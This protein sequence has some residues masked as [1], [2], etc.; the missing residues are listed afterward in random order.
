MRTAGKPP[1]YIQGENNEMKKIIAAVLCL[2]MCLALLSACGT[3]TEP[4]PTDTTEPVTST[5]PSAE[6]EESTDPSAEPSEEPEESTAP[7][8]ETPETETPATEAPAT[9]APA[10]EAPVTNALGDAITAARTDEENEAYQVLCDKDAIEDAYYQVVGFT[11][12][13]V[14]EIA[15]SVSLINVKAYG[16]VVVKPAEGCADTVKAGLQAF[17]DTQCANFETYLADQYEIA[18]NA[19]LE[20]LEDGTIVMVMCENADSVYESIVA[21]LGA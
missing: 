11:S 15:M 18:K 6:P 7:E 8:T 21:S 19:K 4:D 14:D 2:T 16:I 12:S 3:E 1:K 17:I 9:E 10:T 13:D 20:T 5:E